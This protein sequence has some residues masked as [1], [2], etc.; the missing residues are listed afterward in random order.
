MLLP[1]NLLSESGLQNKNLRVEI[2]GMLTILSCLEMR[3]QQAFLKAEEAEAAGRL[4]QI[5]PRVHALDY[6]PMVH[7]ELLYRQDLR[8]SVF[9][10]NI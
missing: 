7:Q 8:E 3:L 5:A 6:A 2:F 1:T 4:H 9:V 10:L